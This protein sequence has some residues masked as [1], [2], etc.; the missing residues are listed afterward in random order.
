MSQWG[1]RLA[2]FKQALQFWLHLPQLLRQSLEQLFSYGGFEICT[3]L[4]YVNNVHKIA[5]QGQ[6]RTL[7][8]LDGDI[9]R[10]IPPPQLF[11]PDPYWQQCYQQAYQRHQVQLAQFLKSLEV[12][13]VLGKRLA[14]AL[15]T[16]SSA[17][18]GNLTEWQQILQTLALP[19]YALVALLVLS[20]LGMGAVVAL[21]LH[22][23]VRPLVLQWVRWK[24]GLS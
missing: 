21:I 11:A 15:G 10:F 9:L 23:G 14:I 7:I 5:Y 6:F 20:M 16:L 4:D 12:F 18:S 2:A 19:P 13:S 8:Q 24:L 1:E 3:P 22:Y 17:F